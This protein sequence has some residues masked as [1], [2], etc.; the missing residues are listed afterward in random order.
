MDVN[1]VRQS[2]PCAVA[3]YHQTARMFH[4]GT[5][6]IQLIAKD[7]LLGAAAAAAGVIAATVARI[8]FIGIIEGSKIAVERVFGP[9]LASDM[10][11]TFAGAVGTA[12]V[13]PLALG[14]IALAVAE[15][16]VGSVVGLTTAGSALLIDVQ[17][18]SLIALAA[19]ATAIYRLA[20]RVF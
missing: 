13:A 15:V 18:S 16:D 20:Q 1:H 6:Q 9:G 10:L 2:L 5:T 4:G 7:M 3:A 8:V 11:G 14:C 19:M 12:T 17:P